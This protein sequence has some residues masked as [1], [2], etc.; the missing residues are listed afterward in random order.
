MRG[1]SDKLRDL[2]SFLGFPVGAERQEAVLGQIEG[3]KMGDGQS[4]KTRAS[5]PYSGEWMERKIS[6][7][8]QFGK[9]VRNWFV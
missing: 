5:S 1:W 8:G 9:V 2:E 4:S 6:L 7:L 3:E